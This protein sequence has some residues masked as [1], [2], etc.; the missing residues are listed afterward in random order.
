MIIFSWAVYFLFVYW[1]DISTL[2]NS[3]STMVVAFS[4][5]SIYLTWVLIVG[6]TGLIDF[7][8]YA[9]ELNFG[10]SILN[11]LRI[12]RCARGGEINSSVDLPVELL[13]FENKIKNFKQ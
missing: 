6:V 12:E 1:V 8:T 4:S 7:A 11:I 9:G 13:E 10:S 5:S 2:F 3:N